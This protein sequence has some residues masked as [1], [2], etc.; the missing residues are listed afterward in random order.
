MNNNIYGMTGGQASPTTPPGAWATTAPWGAIDP[1]FDICKLAEGAGASYVARSTIANPKQVEQ[2]IT[3]GIKNKGFS[4]IEIITH[5][6]TQF[7]RKNNRRMP[8]DNYN[9][10]K[11][12]SVPLSKAKEMSKEELKGK[13]VCGE[14]LTSTGAPEYT[15]EYSKVIKKAEGE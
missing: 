6:H 15:E 2:Y 13:I 12:N 11:E 14:F 10:F 8:I 1:S 4:V 7:G 5:C 3:N 9:F